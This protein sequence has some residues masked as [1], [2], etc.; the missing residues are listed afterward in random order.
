LPFAGNYAGSFFNNLI[1]RYLD[2]RNIQQ[3]I[4]L[5]VS[6]YELQIGLCVRSQLVAFC[7]KTVLEKVIEQNNKNA[8]DKPLRIFKLRGMKDSLRIDL[9]THKNAYQS[10]F[11]K[12][13]ISLLQEHVQ[14]YDQFIGGYTASKI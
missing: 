11:A 4:V 1:K 8:Y 10:Y 5:S 7:P 6:D 12:E 14:K 2:S 13:F 9:I 3:E